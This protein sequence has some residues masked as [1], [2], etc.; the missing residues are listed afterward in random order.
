MCLHWLLVGL[1]PLQYCIFDCLVRWLAV[2]GY[3]SGCG[4]S[5]A[6]LVLQGTCLWRYGIMSQLPNVPGTGAVRDS[7]VGSVFDCKVFTSNSCAIVECTCTV[8]CCVSPTVH[9]L[10]SG[11]LHFVADTLRAQ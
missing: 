9:A 5:R 8:Q 11:S 3:G 10:L 1:Q 7:V 4:W 2:L 6:A